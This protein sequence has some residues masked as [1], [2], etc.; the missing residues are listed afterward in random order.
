VTAPA[1]PVSLPPAAFA[2]LVGL[3]PSRL[4]E[5]AGTGAIPKNARG[6]YDMPQAL[7]SYL[8]R[9]RGQAAARTAVSGRD[10]VEERSRLAAAQADLAELRATEARGQLVNAQEIQAFNVV[11]MTALRNRIMAVPSETK[12][13]I[14]HLEIG[15]IEILE[16]LITMAL[17]DVVGADDEDAE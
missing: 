14:P 9:L 10:L 7:H 5:L 4:R 17:E 11:L 15:E 13:R 6:H 12:N 8:E 2:R 1:F 3:S 16:E